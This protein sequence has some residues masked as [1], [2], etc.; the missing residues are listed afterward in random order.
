M[1]RAKRLENV[2]PG[3]L[4]FEVNARTEQK[5]AYLVRRI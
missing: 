2:R 4:L 5:Q 1:T 3:M